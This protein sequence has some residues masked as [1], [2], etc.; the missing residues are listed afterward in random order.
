LAAPKELICYLHPAWAPLIRPAGV[1][2]DWMEAAS[3]AFPHRCLP[4]NIANAHGWEIV[5]PCGVE[6]VWNGGPAPADVTV[7][8]DAGA[9]PAIAPVA[10]FGQGVLTFHIMGIFRTPPGWSLWIGG[11]PNQAKDAIAPPTGIVETDWSPFTFTMNW[12]FTRAG[13]PVRFAPNETIATISPIERGAVDSFE[14]RVAP[15]ASD[16]ELERTFQAW[17]RARDDFHLRMQSGPPANPSDKWQKHY[18]RGVDVEDRVDIDDHQPK[19]RVKTFLGG[20]AAPP[21]QAT[22]QLVAPSTATDAALLAEARRRIATLEA[23]VAKRD[24]LLDT[25]EGQRLAAP[26]TTAILRRARLDRRT[27]LNEHYAVSRPVIVSG[28]FT[29]WSAL[30]WTPDALKQ[31]LGSVEVEYQAGRS[32]DAAYEERMQDHTRRGPF[33]GF[34]DQLTSDV[35]ARLSHLAEDGSGELV[36]P[37]GSFSFASDGD[38]FSGGLEDVEGE[39][40]QDGEVCGTM[41]LAVAGAI[42]V[43]GCVEHPVEAVLDG[44]VGAD[45][46]GEGLGGKGRRGEIEASGRTGRAIAGD[47]SLDHGERRQTG[48]G[49]LVGVAPIGKEPVERVAHLMGA[50]LDPAVIGVGC[51]VAGQGLRRRIG[52]E[53]RH[54]LVHRRA[55]GLAREQPLAATR[56]DQFGGAVLAMNG[57]SGDQHA[58]QVQQAQQLARGGDLVGTLGNGR[59]ADD[60]AA[61]TSEG[62][63]YVQRRAA[64]RPVEGSSQRLAVDRQNPL[65]LGA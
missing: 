48:H 36:G 43:E 38:V 4:L 23:T 8:A 34:I 1:K 22:R 27:F 62:A 10:I 55:I 39:L 35:D 32:S 60:Q 56:G 53:G 19:L 20:P 30:G 13:Q 7:R 11:P 54:R 57:V 44:P 12:Q 16:P 6:A 9:D 51:D 5:T 3:E 24:W 61:L 25:I 58:G 14:A 65:P 45:G 37:T 42:F 63:D 47:L 49:G 64:R 33:S 46:R 52:E 29:G 21:A 41:I 50:D 17:S 26:P 28:A 18:Y 40:A 2:R 15:L 59:L 31:R